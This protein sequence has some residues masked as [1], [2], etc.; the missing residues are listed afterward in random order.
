MKYIKLCLITALTRAAIKRTR[1]KKNKNFTA[2]TQ[3]LNLRTSSNNVKKQSDK[4]LNSKIYSFL[5]TQEMEIFHNETRYKVEKRRNNEAK[6]K[7]QSTF[8]NQ[9]TS[10]VTKII[11]F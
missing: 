5:T 7:Y 3:N 4:A 1:R 2:E 9:I 6:V 8:L 11:S 10:I